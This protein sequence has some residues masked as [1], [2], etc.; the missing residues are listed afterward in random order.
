MLNPPD[1]VFS[2]FRLAPSRE[3]PVP[4]KM[5]RT[6]FLPHCFL[7]QLRVDDR[8]SLQVRESPLSKHRVWRSCDEQPISARRTARRGRLGLITRTA[9]VVARFPE[10]EHCLTTVFC[11]TF[12]S[13]LQINN[14]DDDEHVMQLNRWCLTLQNKQLHH[15]DKLGHFSNTK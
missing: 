13:C 11:P 10:I 4:K 15:R 7:V 1:K 12:Q 2:V 6:R 14:F 3:T 9:L 5:H 8:R